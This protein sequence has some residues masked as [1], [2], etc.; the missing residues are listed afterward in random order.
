MKL[1]EG[2]VGQYD[3]IDTLDT[4]GNAPSTQCRDTFAAPDTITAPDT[5][6]AGSVGGTA[7]EIEARVKAGEWPSP[8]D[9]ATLLDVGRKTVDRMLNAGLI[10]YRV[11]PGTGRHRE[12][13]P[14]DVLRELVARRTIHG[15]E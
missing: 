10:R 14:D 4:I 5:A 11:K 2:H 12:C 1:R 8:G 9:V 6:E 7:K 15:T 3:T 13:N